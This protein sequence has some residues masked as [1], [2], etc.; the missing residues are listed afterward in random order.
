[1]L[2][3]QPSDEQLADAEVAMLRERG[4]TLRTHLT[5]DVGTR[6]QPILQE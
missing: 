3:V 4:S 2:N 1:M 6:A 5:K